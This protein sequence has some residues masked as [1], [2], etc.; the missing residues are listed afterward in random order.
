MPIESPRAHV[1]PPAAVP[2]PSVGVARRATGSHPDG[3]PFPGR[4]ERTSAP[5]RRTI[6]LVGDTEGGHLSH[7]AHDTT[8]VVVRRKSEPSIRGMD[9]KVEELAHCLAQLG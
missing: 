5:S 1:P 6:I 4:K 8:D 9:V 7:F 3:A 2:R